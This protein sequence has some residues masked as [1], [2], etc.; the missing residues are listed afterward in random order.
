[1]SATRRLFPSDMQTSC[2]FRSAELS[3]AASGQF[4]GFT[5][6]TK[7]PKCRPGLHKPKGPALSRKTDLS[8]GRKE[9]RKA[10]NPPHSQETPVSGSHAEAVR[11]RINLRRRDMRRLPAGLIGEHTCFPAASNPPHVT[12]NISL[13]FPSF[14]SKSPSRNCFL[15][16]WNASLITIVTDPFPGKKH[17]FFQ[18]F[19][20]TAACF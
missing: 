4:R 7:H 19:F 18:K 13:S 17:S 16:P 15:R 9:G 6:K 10:G 8:F 3:G 2:Q 1:M 11:R 20:Q 12:S 5:N 14:L